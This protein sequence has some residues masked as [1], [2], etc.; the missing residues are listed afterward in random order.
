MATIDLGKIKMV[1]RGTYAGGTAYVPDDVVEYTDTAITSSYICTANSTGNAPSS[2]GTAHASWAYLAKG[3]AGS[4]TTARGDIIRRGASADE[5]L[6]KGSAGQ[7]LTMGADDPAWA[8]A[9][10]SNW[11]RLANS[12]VTGQT[13]STIRVSEFTTTYHMYRW[14]FSNLTMTGSNLIYMRLQKNADD[15]IQSGSSYSWVSMHPYGA[16]SGG[17]H[18]QHH[19]WGSNKFRPHGDNA[20]NGN[21][22]MH[23][24][25]DFHN[26]MVAEPTF[27]NFHTVGEEGNVSQLNVHIGGGWY[28]A[29]EQH[30]GFEI[31]PNGNTI[32]SIS[33]SLYGIK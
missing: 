10:E 32:S 27:I 8:A 16:S 24:W 11:V 14:Y 1:W 7:I 19:G 6:A 28:N 26:P 23:G 2:G 17:G 15:A 18:N 33:Y 29:D 12:S 13:L 20:V 25:V 31:W 3:A 30:K 4:P 22:G 5:R 9:P 21:F